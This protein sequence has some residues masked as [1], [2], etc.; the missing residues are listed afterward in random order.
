MAPSIFP[1]S[2][3]LGIPLLAFHF[4]SFRFMLKCKYILEGK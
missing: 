2:I 3:L 1:V 4:L